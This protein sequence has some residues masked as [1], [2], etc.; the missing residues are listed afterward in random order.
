MSSLKISKKDIRAS[1]SRAASTY[2]SYARIQQQVN[3]L[4]MERLPASPVK[5]ILEIGCGTGRLTCELARKLRPEHLLA[6]DIS[7]G[8]LSMARARLEKG[9]GPI[10]LVCCDAEQICLRPGSRFDLMVS[11][12]TM[13]W[14]RD[15]SFSVQCLVKAHLEKNGLFLA[16]LFGSRTLNELADAL[17]AAFPG[18]DTSL[19]PARF[20]SPGRISSTLEHVF[21]GLH[22]ESTTLENRYRDLLQLLRLFRKTGVSPRGR[23]RPPLLNS[24]SKVAR[25][26]RCYIEKFG[27]IRATF[28]VI[29]ISGTGK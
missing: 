14:F 15:F 4:L 28:E 20:P 5:N 24:P 22:V 12:S 11:A 1:F 3:D 25:L 19:P 23:G 9:L 27:S 10:D 16:A 6:V 2:D 8:M 17:S 29:I 7:A 18:K 26:E 13:Q 21:S